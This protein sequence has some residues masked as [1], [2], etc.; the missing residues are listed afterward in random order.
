MNQER[1]SGIRRFAS[2]AAIAFPVTVALFYL[3]TR[4]I[5]PGEHDRIVTRMIRNIEVHHAARP[6]VGSLVFELPQAIEAKPPP[7]QANLSTEGSHQTQSKDA[8]SAESSGKERRAHVIDWWAEARRLTQE[9]DEEVLKR[10]LLEQGYESYVSIM[11]GPLPLTNSVQAKL[12]P[13]QEDA[14]GYMNSYGDMEYK[15]SENCVATT[16]VAAR[17]DHSDL[18]RALP[19]RI[20][21]KSSPKQEFSFD[22]FDRFDRE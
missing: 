16:Q 5:L 9:S 13:T 17:L 21:C 2:S 12:P 3:M 15:I 10:W 11:Q 4:L 8:L 18:A 19:M 7:T 20:T 6:P 1:R 22:R 14:T